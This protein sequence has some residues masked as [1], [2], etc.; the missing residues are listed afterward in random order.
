MSRSRRRYAYRPCRARGGRRASRPRWR[1]PR[2]GQPRAATT[3]WPARRTCK[4]SAARLQVTASP[5]P[6]PGGGSG[7]GRCRSRARWY[8]DPRDDPGRRARRPP[9]TAT[10][11]STAT[12][13]PTPDPD[14]VETELPT[15]FADSIEF[16][17]TGASQVQTG[18]APGTIETARVAVL[19]G[20]VLDRDGSGLA[21]VAITVLDHPELGRTL[22]APT[23]ATTWPSTA[24]G[25]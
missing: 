18:V 1:C 2:R 11:T 17:Y 12:P 6:A 9:P 10:P 23:A 20:R 25:R 16:L 3:C 15:D 4:A 19:R 21:G 7:R 8:A 5:I 22:P 14:P 24:A 13:A